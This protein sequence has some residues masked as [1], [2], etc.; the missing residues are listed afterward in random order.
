MLQIISK[1]LIN[2]QR[3][4]TETTYTTTY[5]TLY[6]LLLLFGNYYLS[7]NYAYSKFCMYLKYYKLC[8]YT[9]E[10]SFSTTD[11]LFLLYRHKL[12]LSNCQRDLRWSIFLWWHQMYQSLIVFGY[13]IYLFLTTKI[14]YITLFYNITTFFVF[15]S[16]NI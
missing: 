11:F 16:C 2:S 14:Y 8:D 9:Y 4:E 5:I 10:N 12:N 6:Y 7:F 3:K 1:K 13:T 15:F